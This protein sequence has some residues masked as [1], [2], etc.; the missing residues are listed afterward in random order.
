[1]TGWLTG[2]L[3]EAKIWGAGYGGW[4]QEGTSVGR[5]WAGAVELVGAGWDEVEGWSGG[6]RV[7][8]LECGKIGWEGGLAG[9]DCLLGG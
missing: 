9:S 2:R 7:C 1:M 6:R 5:G 8:G 3:V 4:W